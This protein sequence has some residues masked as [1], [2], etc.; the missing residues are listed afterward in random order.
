MNDINVLV[1]NG[2]DISKSLGI[3]QSMDI[4][5]ETLKDFISEIGKNLLKIKEAKEVGDMN[6]YSIYVHS[7]KSDADYLGFTVLS[8]LAGNHEKESKVANLVYI[9]NNYI[10]LI[11]EVD[12]IIDITSQYLGV[13]SIVASSSETTVLR[14]DKKILIADDSNIIRNFVEKSFD[15]SVGVCTAS[16]GKEAIDIISNDYEDSVIGI[17]LDLNM[18]EVDGFA[19]LK[20]LE[21]NKLFDKYPVSII[22]G[23]NTKETVDKVFKY[24]VVDLLEKPF[25]I[26]EIKAAVEK[27][28]AIKK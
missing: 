6:N 21:E 26:A 1:N 24:P 3:L 25:S 7:L 5:N 16:D 23:D 27:L 28:L 19:V 18:P 17:L 10:S 20:Y 11:A 4:Y 8:E 14:T 22:T 13:S 15:N 9:A 2:V 12:R